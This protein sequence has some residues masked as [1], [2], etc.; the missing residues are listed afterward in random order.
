MHMRNSIELL[1]K[2]VGDDVIRVT[3]QLLD[4]SGLSTDKRKRGVW[5]QSEHSVS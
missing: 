4:S 1:F 3:T 2:N 5:A